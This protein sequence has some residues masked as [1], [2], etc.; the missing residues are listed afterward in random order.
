MTTAR[1]ADIKFNYHDYTLLPEDKRCEL[2]QGDLLM[3]PAPTT[4]HQKILSNL[5]LRLGA[6]VEKKK[7]GVVFVAPTDVVL[8]DEDVVQPDLLFI[9]NDRKGIIKPENIRGAPDLVIEIL[10]P[11]TAERDLVIKRKLYAKFGVQEYWIVNPEE[12]TV[13]VMTWSEKGFQTVQ[14]FP[15]GSDL[16][17]PLL[18][19]FS[20]SLREIFEG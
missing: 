17:S 2:I 20:V 19:G 5:L 18:I 14:V 3:T 16:H 15:K 12:K 8:S 4:M 6:Y 9:S 7:V 1:Q 10:S 13:E 11:A